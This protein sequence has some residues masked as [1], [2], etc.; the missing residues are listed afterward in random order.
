R[1]GRHVAVGHEAELLRV[2]LLG[3]GHAEPLALGARLG[4]EEIA[5]REEEPRARLRREAEE[6]VALILVEVAAAEEARAL[7]AV[8]DLGVVAGGDVRAA[9]L[10]GEAREHLEL[11]RAVAV[12]AR[13]GRPAPAVFVEEWL[14][15]LAPEGGALVEDVMRDAEVIA[16]AP[17]VLAILGRAA[18]ADLV[19]ALCVP[20]V[21]RDAHHV[22][23]LFA[24][25]RRGD[26]GV[27]P[28]ANG[29]EHFADGTRHG[30]KPGSRGIAGQGLAA[31]ITLAMA[32][33]ARSTSS[34]VVSGPRL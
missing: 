15:H 13:R 10:V 14:H 24:E 12:H 18:A 16:G 23:T 34:P 2:G 4:L 26:G 27:H 11:H 21:E 29:D 3:V 7:G 20:E 5:E 19:L 9:E 1:E 31:P 30:P 28:S 17:R 6:E 8:D 32:A 25:E 22:V 33:S